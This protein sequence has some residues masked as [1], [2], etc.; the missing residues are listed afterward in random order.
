M[1]SQNSQHSENG[2]RDERAYEELVLRTLQGILG[3]EE[4]ETDEET[5]DDVESNLREQVGRVTPMSLAVTFQQLG[6]LVG[7][8]GG[9]LLVVCRLHRWAVP[10]LLVETLELFLQVASLL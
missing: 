5:S 3:L 8:V 2:I 9:E 4:R 10:A 1:P 7:P 6:N